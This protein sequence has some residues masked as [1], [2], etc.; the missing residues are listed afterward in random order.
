MGCSQS[1]PQGDGVEQSHQTAAVKNGSKGGAAKAVA[2]TTKGTGFVQ[3]ELQ[4]PRHA[5]IV[6]SLNDKKVGKIV[7]ALK[8]KEL[9]A[10][11]E[12]FEGLYRGAVLDKKTLTVEVEPK[13]VLT[14]QAK[15]LDGKPG[16][17]G[18]IQD[19]ASVID[20][21]KT[22]DADAVATIKQAELFPVKKSKPSA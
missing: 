7:L 18:V 14:M 6:V 16:V 13:L 19:G 12:D 21:I 5:W 9:S 4:V 11:V 1:Q 15:N 22:A 17:Y 20:V 3:A 8:G 2:D 10:A